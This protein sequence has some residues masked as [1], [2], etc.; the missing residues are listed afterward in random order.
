MHEYNKNQ[1][2]KD[3]VFADRKEEMLQD[4]KAR[5]K[6]IAEK[7]KAMEKL[8]ELADPKS[9]NQNEVNT[10]EKIVKNE[11]IQT[12]S[13]IGDSQEITQ[14]VEENTPISENENLLT[15]EDPWMQRKKKKENL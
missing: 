6:R 8:K 3:E 12:S 15:G 14:N 4:N 5:N 7:N 10:Q 2:Y 9:D 1:E 11:I 13:G